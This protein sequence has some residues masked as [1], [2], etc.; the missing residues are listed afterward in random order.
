MKKKVRFIYTGETLKRFSGMFL[1]QFICTKHSDLFVIHYKVQISNIFQ[2]TVRDENIAETIIV[3]VG[4][5]W[6]PTPISSINTTLIPDITE[7]VI[8]V[9]ALK[10]V[11]NI[12]RLIIHLKAL[13][14]TI[15]SH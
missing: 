13:H 2:I 5:Q 3:K 6:R 14:K 4:N 8:S 10:Y 11:S 15:I 9:I 1:L 12:L 7:C